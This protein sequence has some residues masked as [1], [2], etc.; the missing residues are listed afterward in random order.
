[1]QTSYVLVDYENVQPKELELLKDGTFNVRVFLGPHQS[2]IPVDLAQ[3][4]QPLGSKAEYLIAGKAGRNALDFHIAYYLGLLSAREPA[5][6]FHIVSK[7][8]GF[9]PLIAHLRMQG[10]VVQRIE[11]I[12]DLAGTALRL[13]STPEARVELAVADLIR[14]KASRPRTRKTLLGT[15]SALFKKALSEQELATLFASLCERGVVQLD[16]EKV[17]YHLPVEA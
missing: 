4:L 15:L 3:G 13:P 11:S 12:R 16:G 1:M 9:D 6:H 17:S 2:R 14:R 7:D 10:V 5:A 8:A